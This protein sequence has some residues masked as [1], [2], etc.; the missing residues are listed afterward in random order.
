MISTLLYFLSV[1]SIPTEDGLPPATATLQREL[2]G[3]FQFRLCIHNLPEALTNGRQTVA[4]HS[5]MSTYG[6][7]FTLRCSHFSYHLLARISQHAKI[8]I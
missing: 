7:S 1:E 5:T 4:F 6:Q 3:R 8:D 2:S